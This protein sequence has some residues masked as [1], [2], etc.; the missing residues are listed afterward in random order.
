MKYRQLIRAIE[1]ASQAL[2]GRVASVANQALVVRNWM[3]GPTSWSSS[4]SA[5][6]APNMASN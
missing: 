5:K 2:G 6:T 4:N 3:V 1:S